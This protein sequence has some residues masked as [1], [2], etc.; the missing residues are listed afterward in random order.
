MSVLILVVLAIAFGVMFHRT[1]TGLLAPSLLSGFATGI[2]F[3]LIGFIIEG[4]LDP[5]ALIS[6]AVTSVIGFLV[7]LGIGAMMRSS[8]KKPSTPSVD[9]NK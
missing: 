7:A 4:K 3:H 2:A 5:L 6:F 1:T 9:V 8:R